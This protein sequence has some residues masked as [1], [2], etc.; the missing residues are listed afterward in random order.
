V[1]PGCHDADMTRVGTTS[2]R[3][4]PDTRAA[5]LAGVSLRR[6]RYWEAKG[7]LEPSTVRPISQRKTVR[8]Y[9]QPTL[10]ELLVVAEMRRTHS[11][12]QIRAVVGHLRERG[13]RIREIR[14]ATAGGPA[15]PVHFQM[16]DGS[17]EHKSHPGQIVLWEVLDLRP[18]R[19]RVQGAF[20]RST[21]DQG[22]V[23]RRRGRLG[24]KPVLAGTRVPVAA[25]RAYLDRGATTR[26]I[27]AAYPDLTEADIDAVR[28]PVA[29]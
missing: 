14:F 3:A 20:T 5:R 1:A 19:A 7:V 2:E 22:K 15:G 29:V 26:E 16:P 27:L 23:V 9:D 10:L 6:L 24:S 21:T 13:Y 4:M 28:Q 8:L 18:L 17:W 12:Q 11:L 25:V